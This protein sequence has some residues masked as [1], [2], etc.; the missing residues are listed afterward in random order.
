MVVTID[1]RVACPRG[2]L[3]IC[4]HFSSA[5]ARLVLLCSDLGRTGLRRFALPLVPV[6][7]ST[8]PS[9][10]ISRIAVPMVAGMVSS[11]I[12]TL[13][14]IPAIYALAK[15]QKIAKASYKRG[16]KDDGELYTQRRPQT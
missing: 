12:L 11:T 6:L 8:L 9:E 2:A 10:V 4:P 3:R 1:T 14:V 7:A 16:V 13:A 15:Q 5:H